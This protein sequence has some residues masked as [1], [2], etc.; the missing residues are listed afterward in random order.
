MNADNHRDLVEMIAEVWREIGQPRVEEFILV[1]HTSFADVLDTDSPPTTLLGMPTMWSTF[2]M[3][4]EYIGLISNNCNSLIP[5]RFSRA[6]RGN[7]KL[8]RLLESVN[9]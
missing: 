2:L 7:S 1:L 9:R 5:L 4:D 8:D 3:D 6:L